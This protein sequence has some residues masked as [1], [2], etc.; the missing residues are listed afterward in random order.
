MVKFQT[1]FANRASA[2]ETVTLAREGGEWKV[3]GY[4]ID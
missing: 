3:V 1:R 2:L 4:V